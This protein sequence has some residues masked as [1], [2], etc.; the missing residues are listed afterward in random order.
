VYIPRAAMVIGIYRESEIV[1]PRKTRFASP[2]VLALTL[3]GVMVVLGACSPKP[4]PPPTD[5]PRP[6]PTVYPESLGPQAGPVCEAAFSVSNPVITA[7]AERPVLLVT[8]E[9]TREKAGTW[10]GY[11]LGGSSDKSAAA[12]AATDVK[13]LVCMREIPHKGTIEV[14]LVKWPEGI[15]LGKQDFRWYGPGSSELSSDRPGVVERWLPNQLFYTWLT[16][17]LDHR[18]V[19]LSE[20]KVLDIEFSPDGKMLALPNSSSDLLSGSGSGTLWDT[21]TGQQIRSFQ[22]MTPL[23]FLPDGQTLAL[24]VDWTSITLLDVGTGKELRNIK[25][26]DR[27]DSIVLSPDGKSLATGNSEGFVQLWDVMTGRE[28]RQLATDLFVDCLAFAPD[29]KSLAAGARLGDGSVHVWDVASGQE[30]RRFLGHGDE[31]SGV[32]FSPDGKVLA[33]ASSDGTVK[34]RDVMTGNQLRTLTHDLVL[35]GSVAFAPDGKSLAAAASDD[36]VRV[37]DVASGQEL[38]KFVGYRNAF[39]RVVFSPDGKVLASV[40][41]DPLASPDYSSTFLWDAANEK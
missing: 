22:G 37:W 34:L 15:V 18:R 35:D 31:V 19:L 11:R 4:P 8:E 20:S 24:I 23:A 9:L 39:T 33:S 12:T 14:R 21:T 16:A 29:G 3:L 7:F 17:M 41:Y 40:G 25:L 27:F 10:Q 26:G 38:H 30:L 6:V 5:T 36:S 1:R 32:A 28:L 2:I 13:T